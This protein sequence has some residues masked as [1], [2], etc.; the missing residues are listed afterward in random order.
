MS[1]AG[2]Q[3]VFYFV[4]S[5]SRLFPALLYS[6]ALFF[7]VDSDIWLKAVSIVLAYLSAGIFLE[8]IVAYFDSQTLVQILA[9]INKY[10]ACFFENK[11]LKQVVG[12]KLASRIINRAI[13]GDRRTISRTMIRL[14]KG[15]DIKSIAQDSIH[16]WV[17]HF[18]N[19]EIYP[20]SP[21]V[22]VNT[23]GG[24]IFL[25]KWATTTTTIGKFWL[26][27]ELGHISQRANYTYMIS[28]I[29][30]LPFLFAAVWAVG[31]IDHARISN[32]TEFSILIFLI[33]IVLLGQF[34]S[35]LKEIG[36]VEH[37]MV[38]DDFA[39][40]AL[41]QEELN[42]V[43]AYYENGK[44]PL[45]EKLNAIIEPKRR[46][47]LAHNLEMIREGKL[48]EM[49]Y[50]RTLHPIDVPS[51]YS[52]FIACIC[53]TL[54]LASLPQLNL[55]ISIRFELACLLCVYL[56]G[57]ALSLRKNGLNNQVD[58]EITQ[59]YRSPSKRRR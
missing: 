30:T 11:K 12:E 53:A 52:I 40:T 16:V 28:R 4:E 41:E 13:G 8:C 46:E 47:H 44:L 7:L 45:D 58:R 1:F 15:K 9:Y 17:V 14:L 37:E 35:A 23:I 29:G 51:V 33:F 5:K 18:G 56:A 54:G 36:D 21:V 24:H 2:L 31:H 19:S 34:W 59:R 39:F 57:K 49:L 55:E 25:T 27:H 3:Q 10:S 43:A 26:L 50:K 38:A 32:I 48:S 42:K 20:D 6:C 22:F